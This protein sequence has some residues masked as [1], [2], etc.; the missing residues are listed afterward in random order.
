MC[1]P[2]AFVGGSCWELLLGGTLAANLPKERGAKGRGQKKKAPSEEGAR[3]V[4]QCS[5]A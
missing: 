5:K 3:F 2:F 4:S 1:V